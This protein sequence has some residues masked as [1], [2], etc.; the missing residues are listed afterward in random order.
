MYSALHSALHLSGFWRIHSSHIYIHFVPCFSILYL[1]Y[2]LFRMNGLDLGRLTLHQLF[3]GILFTGQFFWI[4]RLNRNEAFDLSLTSFNDSPSLVSFWTLSMFYK[5]SATESSNKGC[6][7]VPN[8]FNFHISV[9]QNL[10]YHNETL[11]RSI[12][13]RRVS[14]VK[15]I[16]W[17]T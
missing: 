4:F 14:L 11:F 6:G 3:K 9:A 2:W 12:D 8:F 1:Q 15:M 7:M 5:W 17:A 10:I 16:F 13:I